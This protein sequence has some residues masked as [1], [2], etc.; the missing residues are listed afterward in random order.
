MADEAEILELLRRLAAEQAAM[1]ADQQSM[2]AELSGKLD[3]VLARTNDIM[4]GLVRLKTDVENRDVRR[5]LDELRD[6]VEA[7]EGRRG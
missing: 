2:R 6:R 1:R 4:A 5:E 3:L 7:I